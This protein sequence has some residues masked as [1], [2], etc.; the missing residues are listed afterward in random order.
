[1]NSKATSSSEAKVR[2]C[3]DIQPCGDGE[4]P[5][6]VGEALDHRLMPRALGAP[7][8]RFAADFTNLY[9]LHQHVAVLM[10]LRSR[11]AAV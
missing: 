3:E 9:R 5:T 8:L 11:A 2:M 4:T 1:M 7:P 6:G 10:M